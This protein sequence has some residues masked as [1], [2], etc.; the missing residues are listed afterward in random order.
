MAS[1]ISRWDASVAGGRVLVEVQSAVVSKQLPSARRREGSTCEPVPNK[2]S[3]IRARSAP[4][5]AGETRCQ[6]LG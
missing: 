3:E 2:P 6:L 5:N 1:I 4:T